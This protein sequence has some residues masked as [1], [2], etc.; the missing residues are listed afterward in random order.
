MKRELEKEIIKNC[1]IALD[2]EEFTNREFLKRCI[3]GANIKVIMRVDGEKK[4]T[5]IR[6]KLMN[7]LEDKEN[8]NEIVKLVSELIVT[9]RESMQD[10]TEKEEKS[11]KYIY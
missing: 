8:D 6:K 7:K 3:D 10:E 11:E 2:L 9:V 4:I 5:D 1:S